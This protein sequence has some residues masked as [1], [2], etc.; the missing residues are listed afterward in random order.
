MAR[1]LYWGSGS[2]WCWRLQIVL[3]EKGVDYESHLISFSKGE[4]KLP[5]ITSVNPRGQVP[6][7]VDGDIVVNESGAACQYVDDAY[8]NVGPRLIPDDIKLKAQVL[9]FMWES[10]NL[11]TPFSKI[12][13]YSREATKT[14]PVDKAVLKPLTE[15]LKSELG[16]WEKTL[17]GKKFLV[18]DTFTMADAFFYPL[19][20]SNVRWGL[21]FE[22]ANFPAL[23]AY[24]AHISEKESVQKSTPPHWKEG[25]GNPL[26]ADL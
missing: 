10:N 5:Q 26:L 6:T 22:K 3:E 8:P 20:A 21:D 14:G 23:A 4:H 9:Q 19:L 25:P 18:G 11:Y 2:A 15:K 24:H 1:K 12:F 17:T 16:Y 13:E 7:F